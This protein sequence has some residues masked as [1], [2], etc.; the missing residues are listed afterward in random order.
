MPKPLEILFGALLTAGGIKL[1]ADGFKDDGTSN[2]LDRVSRPR[3]RATNLLPPPMR[4]AARQLGM[5][6]R[7]RVVRNI[8]DKIRELRR[9]A[10]VDQHR[11]AE[12]QKRAA[13]LR[14][15]VMSILSRKCGGAWC[16]PEKN[17]KQ[18]VVAIFS[19]VRAQVRYMRDIR[20][21]DTFQ[22]PLYT[23]QHRAGDCDD[24]GILLA[25]LFTLAGYPVKFRVVKTKEA[26]DWDHIYV[27]VGLPPRSP[28]QWMP[29]DASVSKP[30][31][32]EAPDAIIA[33]R[34]DFPV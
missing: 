29:L 21:K 11:D 32:W 23:W 3:G 31:G 22:H 26:S 18:E 14:Q 34:K 16:V 15:V 2:T 25:A 12:G 19:A 28:T 30:A 1:L 17:W 4:P 8:G 10:R 7:E 20:N 5:A 9:L 24:Y 6:M 27:V 33:E 13:S